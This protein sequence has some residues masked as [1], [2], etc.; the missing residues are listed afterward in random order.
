MTHV[1]VTKR[2]GSKVGFD[3][4]RIYSALERAAS[5]TGEFGEAETR[6][7][8]ETVCYYILKSKRFSENISVED[9]QDLA[10]LTPH[11]I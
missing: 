5:A 11:Y 2:D 10:V 6:K 1:H 8:T 9:I 7:I 3:K 4:E